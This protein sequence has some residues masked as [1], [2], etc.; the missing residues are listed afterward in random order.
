[1]LG[2]TLTL[3]GLT[4]TCVSADE[5]GAS[6]YRETSRGVATPTELKITQSQAVDNLSKRPV[7]I[8]SV[9]VTRYDALADGSIARA[10]VCTVTNRT[11]IDTSVSDAEALLPAE[12]CVQLLTGTGADAN[13]LAKASSLFITRDK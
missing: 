13:A 12:V 2:T 3:K 8:T 5:G 11:H 10:S 7:Y 6:I 9:T 1:M 4:F